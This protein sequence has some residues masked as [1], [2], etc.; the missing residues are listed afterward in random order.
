MTGDPVHI[1]FDP[2][3]WRSA[4]PGGAFHLRAQTGGLKPNTLVIW[5][6]QPYR[7]IEVREMQH[8]NWPD[9]Y[10]E[11]WTRQGMPDADTWSYRPRVVVVRHEEKPDQKPLHLAGPDNTMW[12]TLPEHYAICRLC[13]EL[14]PCRHV[15]NE[16][17]M[18]RSAERMDEE[19]ALM[20]GLCHGCR[21]PITQRQKTFTFSGQNLIRPD[22]GDNSAVFHTR[23]KCSSA[24]TSYDKRWA[25]A[26]PGRTRHFYCDGSVTVHHDET[27]ECSNPA[28]PAQGPLADLV[29]HKL[30]MWHH[31]RGSAADQGCW[32][33]AAAS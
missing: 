2:D 11:A 23:G 29:D 14:P 21:E 10:R 30:R 13:H 4:Q 27:T 24:L 32:C 5:N 31:P 18:E 20:P 12:S 19:M 1:R 28:C 22:F 25:A 8:A 7:V 16:A 33:L 9:Q 26:E 17:V 15:Y 6:R 3:E